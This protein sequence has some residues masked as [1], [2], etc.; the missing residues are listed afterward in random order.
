[1]LE[2]KLAALLPRFAF[3]VSA[4]SSTISDPFSLR[5]DF[6]V[7]PGYGDFDDHV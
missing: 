2:E 6:L 1:M 5:F 3:L 7:F 4:S